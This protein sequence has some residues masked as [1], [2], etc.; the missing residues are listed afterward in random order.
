M[1]LLF[2]LR[3]GHWR[4]NA[5]LLK[6]AEARTTNANTAE[7]PETVENILLHCRRH[8]F[9]LSPNLFTSLFT[10]CQMH[11]KRPHSKHGGVSC[12]RAFTLV[13]VAFE[14]GQYVGPLTIDQPFRVMVWVSAETE[15]YFRSLRSQKNYKYTTTT[16]LPST[17]PHGSHNRASPTHRLKPI[18]LFFAKNCLSI[19]IFVDDVTAFFISVFVPSEALS[20]ISSSRRYSVIHEIVS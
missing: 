9:H 12:K 7:V 4:L 2:R 19:S 20:D 10:I 5:H 16:V 13:F 14:S 1:L 11:T 15:F 18:C 8:G 6:L 17:D 3:S